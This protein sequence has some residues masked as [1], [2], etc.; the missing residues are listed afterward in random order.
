M[1]TYANIRVL[2][3]PRPTCSECG[4]RKRCLPQSLDV[5]GVRQ[6]DDFVGDSRMLKRGDYLYRAGDRFDAL[7]LIKAGQLMTEVPAADGRYQVTGFHLPGATLGTDGIDDDV[8]T[9]DIVA[10]Q[11]SVVCPI[12][13]TELARLTAALP[14][15]QRHFHGI[16]SREIIRDH[17]IMLILSMKTAEERV[18]AFLL[19]LS[20][21]F[22]ACG[23]SPHEFYLR[24]TRRNIGS[25]LGIKAET[26]SRTL[27]SLHQQGLITVHRRR[28]QLLHIA[29]L[30]HRVLSSSTGAG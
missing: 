28:V 7:F 25:Y 2:Q 13:F 8:Q 5:G 17:E 11:D 24:M 29:K 21:C 15:L 6:L 27:S 20:Q 9:C 18:V 30:Q 14:A 12:R 16:L 23:Y 26:V 19:Q 4:L 3:F 1:R 22:A 10:L